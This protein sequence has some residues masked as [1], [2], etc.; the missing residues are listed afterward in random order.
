MPGNRDTLSVSHLL[1]NIMAGLWLPL[2]LLLPLLRESDGTWNQRQIRNKILQQREIQNYKSISRRFGVPRGVP[3]YLP[4]V[5]GYITQ[6]LD[7]F[8]RRNNG[9]YQQRFWINEEFWQRP[10]GPVFLFIGG[11]SAE[12]EFSVLA[13]EHVE[14]AEKHGALLVSLEH[15]YYGASI[16]KDGLTLEAI[17]YLSSQQALADLASFHLYISQKYNL[18]QHN[19]WICFGGSYPGSLSAW[20]RLKFPHLVYAAVASSAPVRAELNFKGYNKVVAF[21]LSDPVIGGSEQCL[22]RVRESF[23]VVESLLQAGNATQLE[24]DFSSCN[25]LHAPDDY[26]EFV[27]NLAD[28]FMGAVQ[29]NN[30]I[31][32]SDVRKICDTMV[33]ASTPYQGLKI[34]N[35]EYMDFIGIKC[36][37]NSHE[38]ALEE[39]KKTDLKLQGVGDRQWYYQTCTEFGYYQTCEDVSCPFSPRINLQSQLDLCIQVFQIP[40]DSVSQAVQ[41]TNEY[42]G[43]DHPKSSRIIFVNGD[44]DPWHA[45]S[46]LKNQSRSEIAIYINGTAHCANMSPSHSTDPPSLQQARKEIAMK[47]EEWLK[48]AKEVL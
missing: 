26:T 16:N 29:Y 48:S 7:H 21:S 37:E 39:L 22:D 25:P 12:S 34:V 14:L 20:F 23:R 28:I 32:S 18:T 24:K 27:S 30:E 42:Y 35:S 33:K 15:R 31:P 38:K 19:S 36:V 47:I 13:G 8:N 43:A 10:G 1:L 4:A 45:L 2:L 41:F 5:E 17:R 40:T 9:T 44:V 11:E 6:P 46:V 3:S